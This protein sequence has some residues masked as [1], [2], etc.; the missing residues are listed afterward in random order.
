MVRKLL[1][2][3]N[4]LEGGGAEKVFV[5]LATHLASTGDWELSIAT[6]DNVP[7]SHPAP[8]D[9]TRLRL[10][11]RGSLLRSI[12]QVGALISQ[13][14]P[15]VVL[16]FLTRS[17]CAAILAKRRGDFHCAIS[18]RVHTSSHLG[19]G[20][21]GRL[22]QLIVSW[23]Y[24]RADA[25]IAVSRGVGD[26]LARGYGVPANLITA[27]PNPVFTETLQAR[28]QKEPEIDLPQDFFVAIGRLVPNKGGEVLLRAFA[29]HANMD[30][31]LVILGEGP[32]RARLTALVRALGI[33]GRVH[34]PGY[35]ENPQAILARAT[36]YVSA[37][38]S[39]GFPNALVEAM[40]LG[41]AVMSTDCHS[42]PAEI[43]AETVSGEVE[44]PHQARWGLLVPVDDITALTSAMDLMDDA[45][46]RARYERLSRQRMQ[47]YAPS[48]IFA[49]YQRVLST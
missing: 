8:Q 48:D 22:Q 13:W 9:V 20:P 45:D 37:S 11:C 23:I 47:S 19:S 15:D 27:I 18:E 42:G 6:L 39:E 24:P 38:R 26:E 46:L 16:S 25:V 34:M 3:I 36:A 43:L 28:G 49:R 31:A 12:W 1:L 21:R 32:E 5:S 10:D 40:S 33:E 44:G 29:A 14:Q 7:D 41:R 35:V 17:N 4:S 2:L 30:R